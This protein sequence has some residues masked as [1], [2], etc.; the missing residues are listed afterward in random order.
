M[1][2]KERFLILDFPIIV[3]MTIIRFTILFCLSLLMLQCS[4]TQKVKDGK[5]AFER[6]Q[7]SVATTLLKKEIS[8]EKSKINQGKIAYMIGESYQQMNQ[9]NL[10]TDWFK[11]AYDYNYGP[12]ALKAYSFALKE[13][14][15]YK[16]AAASFKE[17]GIE[18]GSF[19]EYRREIT[20]CKQAQLWESKKGDS[21]YKVSTL[22]INSSYLDFAPTFYNDQE[23]VF[24]SDRPL[25]AGDKSY[26]WTGNDFM[27]LFTYNIS[28]GEINSFD[29]SINTPDNEGTITFN[30]SGTIMIF[31]RCA[32]GESSEEIYCGLYESSKIE[33]GWS[34]PILL[35]F[36]EDGFQYIQPSLNADGDELYFVSNNDEGWGGYDIYKSE[37]I[38]NSWST[39]VLQ[40]RTINSSGNE[41]FPFIYK[42]TLYFSSDFHSGMGGLDVFKSYKLSSNKWSPLDNLKAPINSPAD[43]FGFIVKDVSEGEITQRGYFSSARQ[44]GLGQDD[45]YSFQ[46]GV[47]PSPV[48]VPVDSVEKIEYSIVIKGYVLEKIYSISDNPNSKVLGRKPLANATVKVQFDDKE[49]VITVGEDGLFTFPIEADKTYFFTGSKNEYLNNNIQ[50]SSV[51]IAPTP[52]NPNLEFEVELVLDKVFKNREITLDNIYYDFDRWNIRATAKPTLNAL[53]NTLQLNPNINIQLS[54]HTDCRG[55]ENYNLTL[56]QK[57][58]QSVVDYLISNGISSNR[59]TPVGYGE[60]NPA[61]DCDCNYCSEDEHQANRRTTFK[62]ID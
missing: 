46:K 50:F 51:G 54:S 58:A 10:A 30:E 2:R 6:R 26:K 44:D 20:A 35:N 31:S 55:K 22:N 33:T 1:T 29:N 21:P 12:D 43:D 53:T 36:V 34:E 4:F 8:K 24:T 57:R 19:Y 48:K 62:I 9:P 60:S 13:A 14:G 40:S 41:M 47:P 59:L 18:I 39:P 32:E 49:K 25:A 38:E 37:R 5:T 17:L 42:D 27:D 28:T 3:Q 11:K 15:R 45:I 61:I 23:I 56:S 7:Y 16:D 52:E